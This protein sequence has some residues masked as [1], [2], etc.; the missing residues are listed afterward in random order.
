MHIGVL[1][2]VYDP[3]PGG[4][5]ISAVLAR[6]L[7][8]RGHRVTVLT[9]VPN[10]PHGKVYDGY[11]IR[12]HAIE[13]RDAIPVHRVPLYPNHGTRMAG[14]LANYGSWAL[15]AATIGA[16]CLRDVDAV[17]T[18]YSEATIGLPVVVLRAL[19]KPVLLHV[20][21]LWPESVLHSGFVRP[22]AGL[23]AVAAGTRRWCR[24]NYRAATSLAAISPTMRDVLISRGA[25]PD[26]VHVVYNWAD[27]AVFSPLRNPRTAGRLGTSTVMYA[28][29][30]GYVQS[31]DVAIR[32]AA[33]IR[34]RVPDFRLTIVGSGVA[35]EHLRALAARLGAHNVRFLGRR[36]P[37]EMGELYAAADAQ[38]VSLRDD[39]AFATTVPSKLQAGLA[40]GSPLIV[41][42]RGEAARIVRAAQA[43]LAVAPGDETALAHAFATF[44]RVGKDQRNSWGNAGREFYQ[45]HMSVE[46][47]VA[48][49]ETLLASSRT[50]VGV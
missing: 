20:Q 34:A 16:G 6:G 40:S 25:R 26:K 47:G 15:S 13:I 10:Y 29:T 50:V 5:S 32:A 19:R 18:F 27:E 2:Q 24:M 31:L 35:E 44:S 23:D 46:R 17:W 8:N 49:I 39:P 21:D 7:R 38:L 14:R 4:G 41:A 3:E 37:G 28:G 45:E 48:A 33:R 43:G 11:R 30:L 1:S 12:P 36:P 42:A 9:G 22:G